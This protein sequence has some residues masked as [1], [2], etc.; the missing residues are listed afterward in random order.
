MI[1]LYCI[2][3]YLIGFIGVGII[4]DKYVPG[5]WETSDIIK[6]AVVGIFGPLATILGGLIVWSEF[7]GNKNKES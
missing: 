1:I 7:M 4:L 2:L 3:W 6:L 5:K